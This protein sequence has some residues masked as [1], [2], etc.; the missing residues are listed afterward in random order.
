MKRPAKLCQHLG[1]VILPTLRCDAMAFLSLSA[2]EVLV[3]SLPFVLL[4]CSQVRGVLSRPTLAVLL[5]RGSNF[6]SAS[7]AS[8][9]SST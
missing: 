3:D 7:L 1:R 6:S 2:G 5:Q 4:H 8:M 9:D